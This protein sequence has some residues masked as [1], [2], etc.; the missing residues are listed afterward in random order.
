MNF[1]TSWTGL[2]QLV[3]SGAE[4]TRL[5]TGAT[6]TEGPVWIPQRSAVRWSDI[7]GDRILEYSVASGE[8]SVYAEGVEFTNGRILDQEGAVIQCSHGLRRVE[9][10][11]GALDAGGD[12]RALVDSFAGRRF[13]SPNDVVISMDGSVWFTDPTYGII[14]ANE[15][16]L[17]SQEYG[18][19][20][21]FRFDRSS[22]GLTAVI[23][24]MEQPNG[25]A[26]SPDE[27]TLYVSDSSAAHHNIRA[28]PV[29]GTEIGPG[30]VFAEIESGAP[31]GF[32]VDTEG[33]VW[34][35]SADAVLVFAADGTLLGRI[36]VPEVVSNLCFGGLDGRD[37]FITATTSLYH[38][39][40]L[41]RDAS[42]LWRNPAIFPPRA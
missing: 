33:N 38:L 36:P 35:S 7:P 41:A 32:R 15:G 31:D 25:L 24:D 12:V 4:L 23:T 2:E 39:P 8:S 30:R 26:F 34:T 27:S 13:N 16:H 10:D 17:G 29:S 1:G 11:G 28:Y 22:G 21:V 20:F 9:L 37:L 40:T 6:W 3:P 14:N 5:W 18:G 19:C 42:T